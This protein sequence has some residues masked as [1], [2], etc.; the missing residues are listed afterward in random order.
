MTSYRIPFRSKKRFNL[1]E[2]SAA[3]SEK[4]FLAANDKAQ[5]MTLE[6]LINISKDYNVGFD[7]PTQTFEIMVKIPINELR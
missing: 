1:S 2:L 6:Q 5:E 7:I 3:E 4:V